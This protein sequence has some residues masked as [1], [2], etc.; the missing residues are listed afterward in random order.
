MSLAYDTLFIGGEW[1][2]PAASSA[3]TVVSPSTE[4]VLGCAPRATEREVDAAVVAA[5]A[6]FDDPG[7]WAR[8]EPARRADALER[9]AAGLDRRAGEIARRVSSQNGLPIA[10][11]QQVEAAFP[12]MLL[13][14]YAGMVRDRDPEEH[15]PGLLG[16]STLVRREPIG[17]AGAIVPWNYPQFLAAFKYAPALA[18]GCTVVIKP[19]PETVLDSYLLAESVEEAGFPAG[20]VN[21]VPGGAEIGAYLVS[22]PGVDK[23][24]FTGSTAAGRHIGEVCGRMLR[25]VTLELGGKS[26]AIILDDF[27]LNLDVVGQ[28]LFGATL[29]GNGQTCY[30]STRVLVPRNRYSEIVSLISGFVE[31]LKVGDALDPGTQIGPMVSAKH[32]ERV[33][34][35]ITQGRASGARVTAGGGRPSQLEKGW[36]L[37]PTVLAD[38]DNGS[39]VAQE[40]IF[41][42]VLSLISYGDLDEAVAIAN[43]SAYGLGGTVWTSDPDRAVAVARRVQTGTIGINN[44]LPDPTAP[45]GGVKASGVGR[46]LGPEGLAAYE[47]LK[48]IY[49]Q[50]APSA[51]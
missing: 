27:D 20:V 40:E 12:P 5:R 7:G 30:L 14:Y 32:R 23:I 15:R 37:E 9:L 35:Y 4:E 22:H 21:I 49:L 18:A 50:P 47:Q 24:A 17:V 41:G 31:S 29:L 43:D 33:E 38:V 8:W 46:E 48:S 44:Y 51:S 42:P 45:F 25:S 1:V 3:I 26:A 6:A 2:R 36:F 34:G 39:V 11:S 16:G 10:L 19:S 28:S 13:R